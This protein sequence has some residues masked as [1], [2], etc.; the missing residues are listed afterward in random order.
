MTLH[1]IVGAQHGWASEPDAIR[2]YVDADFSVYSAS[3]NAIRQGIL[4][5]LD[6]VDSRICG[7]PVELVLKN[8][9]GN[10]RRS[11]RNLEQFL[12]DERGLAIF[13]GLHSPPVLENL[14]FINQ[15]G[16]PLLDPWAAAG[17]I[18]RYESPS[19][20]VFRLSVDDTKA[21]EFMVQHVIRRHGA[22]RI[23]L[24]LE[25][26]PWGH[27]NVSTLVTALERHGMSAV[28]V[29]RFNW[30][31]QPLGARIQLRLILDA[32]ADAILM[33]ANVNEGA[34]FCRAMASLPADSRIP[35]VS[36]WGISGGRFL[37]V[38][39]PEVRDL[40]DLSFLQTRFSFMSSKADPHAAHVFAR[41]VRLFP[42]EIQRPEDIRAPDGF[43]HAYDLTRILIAAA[44]QSG[45]SGDV[46]KDRR[47]LCLALENLQQPVKGLV[48]TYEQPF[49][50]YSSGHPDA[51]E[52][53]GGED[54]AMASYG[55]NNAIFL[56]SEDRK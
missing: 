36:H 19:N 41:A 44:E 12:S 16:I 42:G 30:N 33:V 37:E 17:P 6:E 25:D 13:C 18:T 32:G 1:L 22:R 55:T 34:A 48:K 39:G 54:L 45:F 53:L 43:I 5:A 9:R 35:I 11:L 27:S 49:R 4:T 15:N 26:T 46:K 8:H 40:I 56:E 7:H 10:T 50:P 23:A 29:Q 31:L 38:A 3:A 20:S 14:A 47:A 21:G 52:A 2:I 24:L 51:H 28:A